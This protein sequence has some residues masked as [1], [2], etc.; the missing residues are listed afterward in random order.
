M[1]TNNIPA[2][3]DKNGN[4]LQVGDKVCRHNM[5]YRVT[6]ISRKIATDEVFVELTPILVHKLHVTAKNNKS[7][8]IA[9]CK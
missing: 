7:N 6:A 4:K 8:T 2:F 5:R 3:Y 1:K 9:L